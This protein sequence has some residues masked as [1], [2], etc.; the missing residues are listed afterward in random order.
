MVMFLDK[1]RD[2]YS[3]QQHTSWPEVQM[4][5]CVSPCLQTY[6]M[7]PD[8]EAKLTIIFPVIPSPHP[9]VFLFFPV[10]NQVT[11]L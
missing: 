3:Q 6:H 4:F 7:L 8:T 9:I 1:N 11:F 10:L 5:L 2:A